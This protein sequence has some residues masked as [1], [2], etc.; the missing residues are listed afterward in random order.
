MAAKVKRCDRCD[1]RL[2]NAGADWCVEIGNYDADGYG[3]VMT[4]VCP[5]CTT[6]AE[7]LQREI[8]DATTDYRWRGERVARFPKYPQT[9]LN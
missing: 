3:E 2:R 6:S 1:R 8:G 5:D 9:A 7:H 4:V